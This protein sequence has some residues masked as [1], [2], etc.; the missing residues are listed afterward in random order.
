MKCRITVLGIITMLMCGC[1]VHNNESNCIVKLEIHPTS[2][3]SE[4]Y[5]IEVSKDSTI[6]TFYG[7]KDLGVCDFDS[8]YDAKQAVLNSKQVDDIKKRVMILKSHNTISKDKKL[9]PKDSWEY[10]FYIE[11]REYH[12]YMN[13]IRE[14]RFFKDLL[15]C[16]KQLSPITIKQRGFA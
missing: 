15:D 5:V 10:L 11:G 1:D 9:L 7:C 4:V 6:N 8:I 2:S 3:D 13:E 12:F 16:L 14:D